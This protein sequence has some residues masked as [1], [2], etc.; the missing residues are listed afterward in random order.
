MSEA[1]KVRVQARAGEIREHLIRFSTT[2][3]WKLS[4]SGMDLE[5]SE[6]A[7]ADLFEAMTALRLE[8]E[9]RGMRLLCA[10]ARPEVYPSGMSRGMGGGR[11]AYVTRMGQSALM[12]DLIDIFDGA[13]PEDV[14]SVNDQ[15][16]FRKLWVN[17]L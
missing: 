17:S 14:G 15:K 8:L 5:V 9:K 3:P 4:I 6:F 1:K 10:G 16:E 12:T 13:E 2:P 7:G 11:K